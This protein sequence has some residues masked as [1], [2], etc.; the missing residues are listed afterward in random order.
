M[1]R[2]AAPTGRQTYKLTLIAAFYAGQIDSTVA[3]DLAWVRSAADHVE[4]LL[5]DGTCIRD[6]GALIEASDM[7]DAAARTM[8]ALASAHGWTH[9]DIDGDEEA[10]AAMWL[11]AQ[12][13]GIEV[14]NWQPPAAVRA[15]WER[16]EAARKRTAGIPAPAGRPRMSL[17]NVLSTTA[18][19]QGSRNALKTKPAP[20]DADTQVRQEQPE[21]KADP[22]DQLRR[23]P[24]PDARTVELL[25]QARAQELARRR[26]APASRQIASIPGP[27]AS[28]AERTSWLAAMSRQATDARERFRRA[29]EDAPPL[30]ASDARR[31]LLTEPEAALREAKR[32]AHASARALAEHQAE[33]PGAL[34]RWMNL[35][36]AGEQWR[37]NAEA[38]ETRQQA[39]VAALEEAA[40]F[41][42]ERA[43]HLASPEGAAEIRDVLD[44]S[45]LV[46]ELSQL[47]QRDLSAE[48]QE[49]ERRVQRAQRDWAGS[50]A[51]ELASRRPSTLG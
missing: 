23:S 29:A 21:R 27:E 24:I 47:R 46:A 4:A 30:T 9:I 37:R 14:T 11:A 2:S 42:R 15:A 32:D 28:E 10:K 45:W 20:A 50:P 8:M 17:A 12:R 3:G 31:R 48:I 44:R 5:H 6:N 40:A 51:G 7:S 43:R 36:G 16:E 19:A 35:G 25:G 41:H 22:V 34:T 1:V 33:R 13:R 18:A 49:I 26:Q 38:L 39:A